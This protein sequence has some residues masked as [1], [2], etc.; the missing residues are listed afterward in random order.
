MSNSFQVRLTA[1]CVGLVLIPGLIVI[2]GVLGETRDDALRSANVRMQSSEVVLTRLLDTRADM[3]TNSV[4]ALAADFGFRQAVATQ[5][6]DTIASMLINHGARIQ[7][8]VAMFL[9]V[10]GNVVSSTAELA[11]SELF[12]FASLLSLSGTDVNRT[13]IIPLHDQLYQVVVSPVMAPQHIGWLCIGFT[14]DDVLA[15]EL[16]RL[17]GVEVAFFSEDARRSTMIYA[18]T[19]RV[20]AESHL[21][22][23][24]DTSDSGWLTHQFSIDD[25]ADV[26]VLAQLPLETVLLTYR[27]VRKNIIGLFGFLTLVSIG[28]SS[29]LARRITR[30]IRRLVDAVGRIRGGDYGA[31]AYGAIAIEHGRD[32]F[33]LLASTLDEMRKGIASRE[34]QIR[35]Q[36]SYD[37]LT[38]LLNHRELMQ[39]LSK[40]GGIPDGVLLCIRLKRLGEINEAL[41]RE[42]GDQVLVAAA[43]RLKARLPDTDLIARVGSVDLAVFRAS[44]TGAD[45]EGMGTVIREAVATPER[46]DGV[47]AELLA[48]IGAAVSPAHGSDADTV[49]RRSLIALS[50]AELEN[51]SLVTYQNGQDEDRRRRLAIANDLRAAIASDALHMNYQPKVDFETRECHAV[52]ALIRWQHP[53]LGF[54]SPDQFVAVAENSGLIGQ[55]TRWMLDA[56]AR[57]LSEWDDTGLKIDVAVNLSARDLESAAILTLLEDTLDRYSLRPNR[58]VL[59]VTESA[60]IHETQRAARI[61]K[62]LGDRG[63]RVAI[64]DFGTGQSSMAQLG[65]LPVHQLKIDKSFVLAM[66]GNNTATR[67]V[68]AM[69]ELAHSMDLKVVAEGVETLGMWNTLA[70]MD[71]DVAQG[72]LLS[73]P[74]PAGQVS[75]WISKNTPALDQDIE[76]TG[77]FREMASASS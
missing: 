41:G 1:L 17:S 39:K 8:D 38:G 32:E 51:K 54:V 43:R 56:V 27:R 67:I 74:L 15:L 73:R 34:T 61:L 52:E 42:F 6:S 37:A 36:A 5:E 69:V 24:E 13:A 4:N 48:T 64:D 3:L 19:Q 31:D 21:A 9:T 63:F 22:T 18:S 75:G 49:F 57:Q 2:V 70:Q 44:A 68:R 29:A 60:V 71:C 30:P 7:A 59:E 45:V 23:V 26:S 65:S 11:D 66:D 76:R 12:P 16:A 28:L 46:I 77:V 35:R 40:N 72:Y 55:L 58:F 33:G 50:N 10:D 14:V 25:T 20:A 47:S 53:R 62:E